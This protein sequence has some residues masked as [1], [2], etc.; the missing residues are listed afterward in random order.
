MGYR[1]RGNQVVI[2]YPGLPGEF[3]RLP[4]APWPTSGTWQPKGHQGGWCDGC[5]TVGPPLLPKLGR[6]N[7]GR[8]CIGSKH[9]ARPS[10]PQGSKAHQWPFPSWRLSPLVS[11]QEAS[12]RRG[13][14]C[15]Q[16]QLHW[17]L[18]A[19][20]FPALSTLGVGRFTEESHPEKDR[21]VWSQP[22]RDLRQVA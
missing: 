11:E 15:S 12:S 9:E 6:E 18:V 3:S 10:C 5:I 20:T 7:K 2:P 16:R 21:P 4:P 19:F 22:L 1:N 13:P 8:E 14:P 17:P